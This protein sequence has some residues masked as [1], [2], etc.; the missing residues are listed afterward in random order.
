[1]TMM[2]VMTMM[3]M[4]AMMTAGAGLGEGSG[5]G[6]IDLQALDLRGGQAGWNHHHN[7]HHN[8]PTPTMTKSHHGKS[9]SVFQN[10]TMFIKVREGLRS[11]LTVYQYHPPQL[12]LQLYRALADVVEDVLEV[13]P[14]K[15]RG[16]IRK[17]PT[18]R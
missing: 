6:L 11:S 8:K 13:L 1:M 14:S 7:Y 17:S 12:H 9:M 5:L 16:P 4:M 18:M 15:G 3:S 10:P 2:T